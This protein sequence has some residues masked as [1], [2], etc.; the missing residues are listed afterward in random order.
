M[1]GLLFT[2]GPHVWSDSR[3]GESD[4]LNLCLIGSFI[5][6]IIYKKQ[7]IYL[8]IILICFYLVSLIF[9]SCLIEWTYKMSMAVK[10]ISG[11]IIEVH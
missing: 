4:I 8:T 11:L 1:H 2:A 3:R 10:R 9:V 7:T 6:D 5:S